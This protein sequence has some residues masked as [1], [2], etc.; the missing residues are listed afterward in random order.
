MDSR[1]SVARGGFTSYYP[2]V[3]VADDDHGEDKS[4]GEIVE[5]ST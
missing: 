2:D 4:P 5:I 1:L 3:V